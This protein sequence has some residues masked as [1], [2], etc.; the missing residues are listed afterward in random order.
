M[1]LIAY[2]KHIFFVNYAKTSCSSL[3]IVQSIS[4]VTIGCE[5]ECLESIVGTLD[6]LKLGHNLESLQNFLIIELGEANDGT[7]RLD[8]FDNLRGI[9][10]SYSE[11]GSARILSHD[12]AESL[13]STFSHSITLI[14]NYEFV[15]SRRYLN[16]LM[17]ET[18]NLVSYYIDSTIIRCIQL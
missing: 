11:S 9:I 2:F 4:H 13:L 8:R 14:K 16:L 6:L 3:K 12:H 5:N 7:S 15:H 10:T 18:L 1:R 17:S